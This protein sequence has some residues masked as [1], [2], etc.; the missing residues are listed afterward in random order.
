M[1]FQY[2]FTEHKKSYDIDQM[3]EEFLDPELSVWDSLESS[4]WFPHEIVEA[5]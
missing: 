3:N 5:H 2:I 1:N 4:Q